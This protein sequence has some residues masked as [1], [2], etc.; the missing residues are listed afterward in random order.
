MILIYLSLLFLQSVICMYS[1]PF[2][3]ILW[4]EYQILSD[5]QLKW[6]Q[7]YDNKNIIF[8]LEENV[9]KQVITY[10]STHKSNSNN[11]K[12]N[13]NNPNDIQSDLIKQK[14][15]N[16]INTIENI[17]KIT[18][19]LFSTDYLLTVPFVYLYVLSLQQSTSEYE[20]IDG[21]LHL[22]SSSLIVY[23]G[24]GSDICY[25][26]N[27][28]NN[29]DNDNE[30]NNDNNNENNSE[31]ASTPQSTSSSDIDSNSN[32]DIDRSDRNS[33][34]NRVR[35]SDR[36]RII[37]TR[38][39]ESLPIQERPLLFDLPFSVE[40]MFEKECD[41]VKDMHS[42]STTTSNGDMDSNDRSSIR[43]IFQIHKNDGVTIPSDNCNI[44][45]KDINQNNS[46]D[47]KINNHNINNYKSMNSKLS[48]NQYSDSYLRLLQQ[49]L[50]ER[51]K[52]A[53]KNNN[54][55]SSSNDEKNN[56]KNTINNDESDNN[57][58]SNNNHNNNNNNKLPPKTSYSITP[59]F[60]KKTSD[61]IQT[62]AQSARTE[63]TTGK[64]PDVFYHAD[65]S[66]CRDSDMSDIDYHIGYK[67]VISD[68]KIC[69][70][71]D[72]SYSGSSSTKINSD[73]ISNDNS[74]SG[75]DFL[76]NPTN[77]HFNHT[78]LHSNAASN[79]THTTTPTITNN[80]PNQPIKILCL[81]YTIAPNHRSIETIR[82]T[83]G[84]R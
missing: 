27:N 13:N 2:I 52:Y 42:S 65:I 4:N 19:N 30:R 78:I 29:T 7:Y 22:L 82:S 15:S 8:L 34:S 23:I 66:Y 47:N 84:K 60:N 17:Q 76:S 83:W 33:N 43:N 36:D 28:A 73:T 56:D 16:S 81:T 71:T 75:S 32:Y 25:S 21:I 49:N 9:Y 14:K 37:L 31:N 72:T 24:K 39:I 35:D 18:F 54:D 59:L 68:A 38:L 48:C 77:D 57:I 62:T 67:I 55:K 50:I 63:W 51:Q 26:I 3:I 61:S 80:S 45:D 5:C 11:E 20:S 79:T 44:N 12:A 41:N 40:K 70:D 6:F 10:K 46:C 53:N 1:K 58:N 69:N 74:K 64:L